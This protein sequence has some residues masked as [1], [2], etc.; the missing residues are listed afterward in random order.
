MKELCYDVVIAGCG[1]AGLYTALHLGADK[2]I[3]MLAKKDLE[4]CD[5]MLAQGGICVLRDESDYEEYFEDTMRA[6]HYE[7]RKE[8]VD[9]MIRGSRAV[10]E[11]LVN[12]GVR[13]E[14]NEDGSL[15]YTREGAH[16]KPR[17]CF[18]K[19]ITGKEI[20]TTLLVHVKKLSNVTIME[21]TEM[22]DI[23]TG[24]GVCQGVVAQKRD[25]EVLQIEAK[26]VV[27]ATGGIG[28]LYEHS[29]NFPSLTGDS[30]RIAKKHGVKLEHMDY[31][32]IHPTTLYS[33]KPG[34]SFLISE[35]ARGEGA[36]LLNHKGERFV[37]EL[38]PRDVV[39]E[40][41]REEMKKENVKYEYLS[42]EN[43]PKDMIREHFPN[44]C[45]QCLEEGYDI[46]KEPIPIVP[47]QHYFM[48][49]VHVDSDSMTTLPHLY[50]VGETSCNGVH[51]K[52]R[53]ASNSLLESLVFS[54]RAAARIE[55]TQRKEKL[56]AGEL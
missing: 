5:S 19:D 16:S 42:F 4:S 29:T 27:M 23:L 36:I 39:T 17:I 6:G 8:S 37:D 15:A 33:K 55:E 28:G 7:N 44:I 54:K 9:I 49:G 41:I 14:R 31:V 46:F 21:Y 3:L 1:V 20:T 24:D 48:G 43:V 50:A 25:G 35:S 32:Q 56:Q 52:N 30:C 38:L 10:I 13:F 53:L 40:A 18:H 34:R 51:G 12:L 47:A 26:D 22:T 45:R 11:H 2:K